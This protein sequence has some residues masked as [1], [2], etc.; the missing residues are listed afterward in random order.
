MAML[1][2]DPRNGFP[3]RPQADRRPDGSDAS[4]GTSQDHT[5]DAAIGPEAGALLIRL[6]FAVDAM[7]FSP[8]GEKR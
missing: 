1:L 6:V 3:A 2:D 4:T 5:I 8:P 7:V